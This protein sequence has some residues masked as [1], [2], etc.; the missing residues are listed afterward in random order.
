MLESFSGVVG[1][2]AD[3]VEI[4]ESTWRTRYADPVIFG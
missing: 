3:V 2:D 4:T 1:A